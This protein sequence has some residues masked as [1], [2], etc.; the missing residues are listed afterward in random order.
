MKRTGFL[1]DERYLR[2]YTGANHPEVPERL[3]AAFRGIQE[4]GLLPKLIRITA[5]KADERWVGMVHSTEF[6][7]RFRDACS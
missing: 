3:E 5:G 6:I 1:Y 7:T 2:H 4:S